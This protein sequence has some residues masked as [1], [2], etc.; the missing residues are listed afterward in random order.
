MQAHLLLQL[1]TPCR[2]FNK[3]TVAR[4]SAPDIVRATQPTP[5]MPTSVLGA[6]LELKCLVQQAASKSHGPHPL[7]QHAP[8]SCSH[9][10][11]IGVAVESGHGTGEAVRHV[12]H[13]GCHQLRVRVWQPRWDGRQWSHSHL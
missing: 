6:A 12:T 1:G 5:H 13:I 10:V 7:L 8:C 11:C 3:A 2:L 9:R 4:P